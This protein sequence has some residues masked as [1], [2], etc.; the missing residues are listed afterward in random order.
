MT[1]R[2][3]GF[4]YND[5]IPLHS[6]YNFAFDF[7]NSTVQQN[8]SQCV[9]LFETSS[10]TFCYN[11]C[12]KIHTCYIIRR[13]FW[14]LTGGFPEYLWSEWWRITASSF[15]PRYMYNALPTTLLLLVLFWSVLWSIDG[16]DYK[17]TIWPLVLV[18]GILSSRFSIK[19]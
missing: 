19:C 3:N 17:E 10:V 8:L 2:R 11:K 9:G 15:Q 1:R 18:K 13:S 16:F 5:T 14:I 12:Y 6:L 4:C 7:Y